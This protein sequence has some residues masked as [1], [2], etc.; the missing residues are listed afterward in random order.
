LLLVQRAAAIGGGLSHP[1]AFQRSTAL[2]IAYNIMP[3]AFA[4]LCLG[5]D[6]L[7]ICGKLG[8]GYNLLGVLHIA[9]RLCLEVICPAAA[10]VVCVASFGVLFL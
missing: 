1:P 9:G 8:G 6:T 7:N 4:F 3:G 2:V 10:S 5:Y